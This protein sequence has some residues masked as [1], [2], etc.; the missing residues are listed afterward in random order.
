MSNELIV[1]SIA[2]VLITSSYCFDINLFN[3]QYI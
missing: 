1:K 2:V 3:N